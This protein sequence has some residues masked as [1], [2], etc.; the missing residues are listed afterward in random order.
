MKLLMG[1]MRIWSPSFANLEPMPKRFSA[2]GGSHSPP[3]VF[4]DVPPAA[5]ELAL[6]VYDP[7]APT[8]LGVTHWQVYG[9]PPK[10]TA[11]PEGGGA[12]F[13]QGLN[14][15]G[16]PKYMGPAPPPGHGI[17]HY[18]FWLYALDKALGLKAGMSPD[19]LMAA[20]EDHVIE[21]ARWVGL[22]E[23]EA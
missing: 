2:A 12:D 9:I 6:I 17:H 19:D 7:D 5:E 8:P 16:E 20:I 15:A 21:Q 1:K 11:I 13:S 14:E 3:V 10:T 4:T 23:I 18:Y 22:Y